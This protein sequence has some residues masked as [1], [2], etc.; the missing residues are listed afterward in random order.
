ML[1]VHLFR[2][3]ILHAN[4][5]CDLKCSKTPTRFSFPRN[6]Q[7]FFT[8][9]SPSD[10]PQSMPISYPICVALDVLQNQ[11]G[12]L[13]IL[14]EQFLIDNG[15]DVNIKDKKGNTPLHIVKE[16]KIARCLINHGANIR[17]KR[18]SRAFANTNKGFLSKLTVYLF[19]FPFCQF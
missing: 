7:S 8:Q 16:A 18:L 1:Q 5:T 14:G 19:F 11:R 17:W 9:T 4:Q 3:C 6:F 12:T 2:W 15:S 10:F 13:I